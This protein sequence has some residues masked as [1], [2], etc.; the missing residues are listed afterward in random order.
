MLPLMATRIERFCLPPRACPPIFERLGQKGWRR[1][2]AAVSRLKSLP[3]AASAPARTSLVASVRACGASG[4]VGADSG[5]T[6][7]DCALLVGEALRFFALHFR[8]P[9]PIEKLARG[10]GVSEQRLT[11][12]FDCARGI[13]P[14]QALLE[15]RL[16]RLFQTFREHPS[17][18]LRRSIQDCGLG[19]TAHIIQLFEDSFGIALAPFL[20]TCRRAQADQAFRRL[21][22]QRRHLILPSRA[23]PAGL[24]SPGI[25][26]R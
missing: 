3:S 16:N 4:P 5:D 20:L 9:L 24:G 8:Q 11:S 15:F 7:S 6:S 25:C 13:T 1:W 26:R 19:Q 10:L 17:Q 23:E 18:R 22:P 21:H 14:G 2:S 12:C